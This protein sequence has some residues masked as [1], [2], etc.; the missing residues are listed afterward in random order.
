MNS[1]EPNDNRLDEYLDGVMSQQDAADFLQTVDSKLLQ[2]AQDVQQRIDDSLRRISAFEKLDEEEIVHRFLREDSVEVS[3]RPADSESLSRRSWVQLAVAAVVL[4]AMSLGIWFYSGTGGIEPIFKARSLASIYSETV[5]RGF[6]P[7]YLCDDDVRFAETFDF[8]LGQSLALAELPANCQMLGISYPGGISRNTTAM[9]CTVDD[10]NVLVFVDR[11]GEPGFEIATAGA[12][13][14]LNVFIEEKNGLV[15]CE[16]TPLDS[17][18]MI[19][20]FRF[21]N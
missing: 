12:D 4:M 20:H 5:D 8:R 3:D 21:K 2:R 19:E 7:Y 1:N 16:V 13:D 17:A 11:V 14:D 6:K 9:L 10:E 15:F 18:Q